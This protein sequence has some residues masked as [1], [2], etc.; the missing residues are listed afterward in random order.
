MISP[1][2]ESS[3]SVQVAKAH[4]IIRVN[5]S[6]VRVTSR[7]DKVLRQAAAGLMVLNSVENCVPLPLQRPSGYAD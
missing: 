3:K 4:V 5:P 1:E 6:H 7:Q 2:S